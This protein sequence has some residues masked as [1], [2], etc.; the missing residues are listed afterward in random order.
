MF[1]L[2]QPRMQQLAFAATAHCWLMVSL[3]STRI[4]GPSQQ[5][6]FPAGQPQP[7]LVP[8]VVPPEVQDFTLPLVEPREAP[9]SPFLQPVEV[10]LN[11]QPPGVSAT[12][13]GFI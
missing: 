12:P 3:L 8:G 1:I 13:L 4:P 6:C 10:P 11:A 2:T 7:V 9:V 5:S